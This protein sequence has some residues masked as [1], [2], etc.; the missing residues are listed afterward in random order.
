MARFDF[1]MPKDLF[2]GLGERIDEIAPKMIE[3]ASPIYISHAKAAINAAIRH[4]DRSTG[5]LVSSM[6]MDKP[7]AAK[8]GGY[9]ASITFKGKTKGKSKVSNFYKAFALEY[10]TSKQPATPWVATTNARAKVDVET[11]MTEVL[12]KEVG[13]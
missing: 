5:S 1:D 12:Q 6:K 9:V 7:K 13:R 3:A 11:A 8:G 2:S 10:G 4:R